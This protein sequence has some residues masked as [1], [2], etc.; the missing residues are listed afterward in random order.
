M[1]APLPQADDDRSDVSIRRRSHAGATSG[2]MNG[3]GAMSNGGK[4]NG[5]HHEGFDRE[6]PWI[7]DAF[8]GHHCPICLSPTEQSAMIESC[9]HIFCQKC[10][11]EVTICNAVCTCGGV[12][13]RQT[14]RHIG[15]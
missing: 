4:T 8:R 5:Y 2:S 9:R 12:K 7:A 11:F 10:L 14:D 13:E 1:N 15:I 3:N 6:K